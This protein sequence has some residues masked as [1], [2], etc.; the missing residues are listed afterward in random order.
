MLLWGQIYL[1]RFPINSQQPHLLIHVAPVTQFLPQSCIDQ[2]FTISIYASI[3]WGANQVIVPSSA[4]ASTLASAS[5]SVVKPLDTS[6]DIP[7]SSIDQFPNS[8]ESIILLH[9]LIDVFMFF[10]FHQTP[11]KTYSIAVLNIIILIFWGVNS[12]KGN[13]IYETTTI[14]SLLPN[15]TQLNDIKCCF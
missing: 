9:S 1:Q 6:D 5:T 13:I 14:Y 4:S 11:S 15:A 8:D 10:F 12:T 3:L 2:T 7:I